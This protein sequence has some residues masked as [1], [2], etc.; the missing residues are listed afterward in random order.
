MTEL[1][2]LGNLVILSRDFR[3]PVRFLVIVVNDDGMLNA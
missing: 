3:F 2:A 1:P